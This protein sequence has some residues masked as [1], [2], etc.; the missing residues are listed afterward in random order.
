MEPNILAAL[1]GSLGAIAAAVITV[2]FSR[3]LDSRHAAPG[4]RPAETGRPEIAENMPSAGP[5]D[6]RRIVPAR[7]LARVFAVLI[8]GL[9]SAILARAYARAQLN[10]FQ[11]DEFGYGAGFAV[12]GILFLLLSLMK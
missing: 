8:T 1:I 12:I 4:D 3:G 6:S 7:M 2:V 9:G 5:N 11:V 10:Q